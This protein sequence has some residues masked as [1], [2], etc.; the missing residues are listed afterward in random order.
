MTTIVTPKSTVFLD[1][2]TWRESLNSVGLSGDKKYYSIKIPSDFQSLD[3]AC[4]YLRRLGGGTG[5]ASID[6]HSVYSKDQEAEYANTEDDVSNSISVTS[7]ELIQMDI[8]S[9]FQNLTSSHSSAQCG[10]AL[11]NQS[12]ISFTIQTGEFVY[13]S[14]AGTK[15]NCVFFTSYFDTTY[16]ASSA[17]RPTNDVLSTAHLNINVQIPAGMKRVTKA[18]LDFGKALSGSGVKTWTFELLSGGDGE[19]HNENSDT[20]TVDKTTTTGR[21]LIEVDILPLM[22]AIVPGSSYDSG[23]LTL[24]DSFEGL[25]C[26]IDFTNTTGLAVYFLGGILEGDFA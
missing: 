20:N 4:I 13:T 2:G 5:T 18:V 6:L 17:K 11:I 25:S 15:K 22:E 26:G 9:I 3:S 10:I 21:T 12:S 23:T 8:T 1:Y 24:P 7:T 16:G 14:S 19:A